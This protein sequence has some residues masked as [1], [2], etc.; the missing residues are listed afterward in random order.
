MTCENPA[1][2]FKI[3]QDCNS[4]SDC[5]LLIN[6]KRNGGDNAFDIT[7]ATNQAWGAFAQVPQ[8]KSEKMVVLLYYYYYY[9][10][11]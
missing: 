11:F 3:P 5:N 2:C 10:F 6:Y 7:V 1:R 4:S 9:F 8:L